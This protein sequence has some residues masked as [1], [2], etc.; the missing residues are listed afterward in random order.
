MKYTPQLA[1][2]LVIII[3]SLSTALLAQDQRN[4]YYLNASGNRYSIILPATPARAAPKVLTEASAGGGNPVEI[5]LA[6]ISEFGV[7]GSYRY[8]VRAVEFAEGRQAAGAV[9]QRQSATRAT[10]RLPLLE[11]ARGPASLYLF[12]G[13]G[14]P[15]YYLSTE[16]EQF[17]ALLFDRFLNEDGDI[18]SDNRYQQQLRAALDC[19][20]T[21]KQ[22]RGVQYTEREL[23]NAV[24]AYNDCQGGTTRSLSNVRQKSF[25][26]G[27][28][29]GPNIFN[30]ATENSVQRTRGVDYGSG[31]DVRV[32][33]EIIYGVGFGDGEAS[34]NFTP[35]Y[36]S[37]S[38]EQEVENLGRMST[39]VLESTA[40]DLPIG[41][42]YVL[43][44][45]QLQPYGQLGIGYTLFPGG[46]Q[47][48]GNEELEMNLALSYNAAVGVLYNDR[49]G[50]RI[51]YNRLADALPAA[52]VKSKISGIWIAGEYRF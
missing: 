16:S 5:S 18:V 15:Q 33:V 42:R 3:L 32:G 29:L 26:L 22:M 51:T 44:S 37:F 6:D 48:S 41:F 50:L 36:Y 24:V 39:A 30:Y 21:P 20:G 10:T 28:L 12:R 52:A 2:Y 40:I 38:V 27:V 43:P 46:M 8:V 45:K 49:F 25:S 47:T 7:D 14:G 34:V 19:G 31:I 13:S 1:T 35:S 17:V 4:G 9:T 23:L 11:L